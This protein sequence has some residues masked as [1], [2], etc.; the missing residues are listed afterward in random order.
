MATIYVDAF[1]RRSNETARQV[2][3]AVFLGHAQ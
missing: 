3:D 1:G 2:F